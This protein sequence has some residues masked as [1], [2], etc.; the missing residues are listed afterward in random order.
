MTRTLPKPSR[1]HEQAIFIAQ[2]AKD[3]KAQDVL[4]LKVSDLTSI[5]DYFI[6]AS[7]E[8]ERQVR[9]LASVIEKSMAARYRTT[10]I[11]EGKETANW[12]LLD[13]GRHHCPYFPVRYPPVLCLRKNVG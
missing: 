6:F 3:K 9:G 2:A 1:S 8:S 13:Y 10:P 11:I 4:V 5:A 7:G 12:M